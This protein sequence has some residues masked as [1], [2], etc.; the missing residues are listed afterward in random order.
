M[1]EINES[2]V[3]KI[4]LYKKNGLKSVISLQEKT[5]IEILIYLDELY[6]N[7]GNILLNDSEYDLLREY[8]KNKYNN[9]SYF[10]NIGASI[11]YNENTLCCSLALD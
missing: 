1:Y 10:K 11:K 7:S 5:I 9:N 3:D 4:H 6:Y 8:A 2:V